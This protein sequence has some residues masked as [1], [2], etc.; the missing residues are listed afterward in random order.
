V[1]TTRLRSTDF[2]ITVD[3]RPAGMEDV[4]PG[5][6]ERDRLGIVVDADHAAAGAG[7]LI[8]AAVTAFYDRLRTRAE[9]FFAYPDYFAFHV[10]YDRGTLRKLD[11]YP[12]DKEIVV[13]ADAAS[14]TRAV[15]ER[16]ITRLLVPD[17]GAPARTGAA[18]PGRVLTALAY[19][20]AG[21]VP[22]A[23]VTVTAGAA[24]GVFIDQMLD[25]TGAPPCLRGDR[26]RASFRR[27]PPEAA[28]EMLIPVP[29]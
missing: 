12:E 26:R 21:D 8:L 24:A 10:G 5:F 1:H 27:L 29:R 23:D 15:A 17:A 2:E 13:P 19:S 28:L 3:G 25:S 7:P 9:D 22:D 18:D 6:T 4:F 14:L 11:V 16:A 20:P